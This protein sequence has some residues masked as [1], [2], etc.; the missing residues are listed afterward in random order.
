MIGFRSSV[1]IELSFKS[2]LC[3]QPPN[4][5]TILLAFNQSVITS[6]NFVLYLAKFPFVHQ[7]SFLH[8]KSVLDIPSEV[9]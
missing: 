4:R 8:L 1:Y 6:Q 5:A 7:K 9:L 2:G 3:F